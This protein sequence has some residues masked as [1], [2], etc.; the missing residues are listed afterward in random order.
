MKRL[1]NKTMNSGWLAVLM[2]VLLTAFSVASCQ[3][4]EDGGGAPVIHYV[5][6]TDPAL[7][8]TEVILIFHDS[9]ACGVCTARDDPGDP[10]EQSA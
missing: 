10:Q 5:R 9:D 2:L 8:D 1:M 7:A 4:D 3:D 6:V